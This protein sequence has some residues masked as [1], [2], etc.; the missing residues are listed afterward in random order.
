MTEDTSHRGATTVT[1]PPWIRFK[2]VLCWV[3]ST[4][5]EDWIVPI[6]R[7]LTDSNEGACHVVM[8]LDCP[9]DTTRRDPAGRP[10][11]A[12]LTPQMISRAGQELAELYSED[13][14]TIVLPGHPVTEVRRYGRNHKMDLIM[15][16]EQGLALE[17]VYGERLCDNAP[18]TV[19]IL[20]LPE[21]IERLVKGRSLSANEDPQLMR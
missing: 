5:T 4:Q 8:C 15:I 11:K 1:L 20:V 19:M 3:N 6:A 17:R 7:S 13:V 18:C 16:G 14:H 2:R 9:A 12:P 21:H 10:N